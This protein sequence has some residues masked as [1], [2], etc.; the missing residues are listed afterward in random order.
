MKVAAASV[1]I[2][3]SVALPA[4]AETAS[5]TPPESTDTALF[6]APGNLGDIDSRPAPDPQFAPEWQFRGFP[7]HAAALADDS[8]RISELVA[9]GFEVDYRDRYGKTPLMVAAA[10]GNVDAVRRLLAL[11]ADIEAGDTVTGARA[12]H[13]A[14]R[15]GHAGLPAA[16]VLAAAGADVNAGAFLGETPLH[17]AASYGHVGMIAFLADSG[18]S[19]ETRDNEGVRPLEAARRLGRMVAVE[20]LLR[21]GAREDTIHDAVNAGDLARVRQ[22]LRAGASANDLGLDGGPLARAAAKGYVAVAAALLDAGADIEGESDPF[23]AHPLHIAAMSDQ[24]AMVAFLVERGAR[25]ESRNAEGR[26]PLMMAAAYQKTAVGKLLVDA[27]ADIAAVDDKEMSAAHHA[28]SSGD[29]ELLLH[30]MRHGIDA[31][32]QNRLNGMAPLH[33]AAGYGDLQV[34]RLLAG[35]G[36]DFRLRD[37]TGRTP[38][39]HAYHCRAMLA[40]ALIAQL[41]PP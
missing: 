1:V 37:R 36:G 28:A 24:P 2:L 27:G 7:L 32:S 12:L 30:L 40:A 15:M 23:S 6:V 25:L 33:Y 41:D 9:S 18:A 22:L 17:L 19:L 11:G 20:T 38:L 39:D 29:A 14:A 5:L 8:A 35:H 4:A 10:F 16:R 34:I 26:T 13:H 3:L 21:L 31:N